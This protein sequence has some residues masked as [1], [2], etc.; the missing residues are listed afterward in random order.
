MKIRAS[1]WNRFTWIGSI[2]AIPIVLFLMFR[3]DW[4]TLTSTLAVLSYVYLGFI[5]GT[6]ALV[7]I[8]MRLGIIIFV[9]S[10]RDKRT[11]LYRMSRDCAAMEK[12]IWGNTFSKKYYD[13]YLK[14]E[15]EDCRTTDSTLSTEGAP[16]VEK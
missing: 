10:P 2:P 11:K 13:T 4:G 7:A 6:G 14:E 8:L 12:S 1:S 3:P 9:Y 16:S 5:G 15:G